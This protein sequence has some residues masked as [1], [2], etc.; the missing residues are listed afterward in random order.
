MLTSGESAEAHSNNDSQG[1][2]L[3]VAIDGPAGAGKSTLAQSIADALDYLYIDTGAMYRAATW[4]ALEKKVDLNDHLRICRLIEETDI[5]LEPPSEEA[6]GRVRV[7]VNGADVT[8]IVRSRIISKFVSQIAAIT[9]VRH[10]L[11]Q[12]QREM[13]QKGG[14]VMD[15]R[16]IGTV[17]LPQAQVKI[18]LTASAETR[19]ARRLKDLESMGQTADISS[20]IE[21]I[22]ARDNFDS[23]RTASP[24]KAAEDAVLI[25]TDG[26]S[27]EEVRTKVLEMC[28]AKLEK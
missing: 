24:L 9:G 5:R 8:M 4:A 27:Q 20:L 14:V 25:D 19:A 16:D 11:V 1:T 10:H 3:N 7:L 18:F 23:T 17:V 22:K 13:A 28:K 6:P 26:L 12:K 15:G 21:E 2:K